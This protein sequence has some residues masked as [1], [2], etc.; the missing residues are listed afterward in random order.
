MVQFA[1]RFPDEQIVASLRRQLSWTH[2]ELNDGALRVASYLTELPARE[3]LER[4]L[5][6]S[7]ALAKAR[8]ITEDEA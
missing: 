6:E 2:L 5:R 3:L 8:I 1:E 7:I 4:K